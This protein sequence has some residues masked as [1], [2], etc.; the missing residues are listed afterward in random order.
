[1]THDIL[2]WPCLT[3]SYTHTHTHTHTHT[4]SYP[5][6]VLTLKIRVLLHLP[7]FPFFDQINKYNVLPCNCKTMLSTLQFYKNS[8]IRHCSCWLTVLPWKF[9]MRCSGFWEKRRPLGSRIYSLGRILMNPITASF[10]TEKKST[11][12]GNCSLWLKVKV[13][14]IQVSLTL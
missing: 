14:V 1:M 13:L 7:V 12:G 11:K 5:C 9:S 2:M 4:D 3:H 10:Q 8:V 6:F